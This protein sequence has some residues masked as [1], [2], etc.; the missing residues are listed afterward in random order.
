M[1]KRMSITLVSLV[2][3]LIIVQI[4]YAVQ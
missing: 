1:E 2:V 4:I 3:L